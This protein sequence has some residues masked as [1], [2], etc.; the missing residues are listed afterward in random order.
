MSYFLFKFYNIN[1]YCYHENISE[2]IITKLKSLY[3]CPDV[4]AI[5]SND[6]ILGSKKI[7]SHVLH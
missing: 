2:Q 6:E 7:C 3:F 4:Y 1:I 5:H